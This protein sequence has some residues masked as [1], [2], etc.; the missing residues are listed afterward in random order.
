MR[1]TRHADHR[2][3][4]RCLPT[5][6]LETICEYGSPVPSKGAVS[7]VLDNETL[8]LAAEDDRRRRIE[9]ERYRGAYVIVGVDGRIITAARRTRRFRRQ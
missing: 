9:L 8:K 6:V 5:R 1:L 4:Q 7:L 3:I 2:R